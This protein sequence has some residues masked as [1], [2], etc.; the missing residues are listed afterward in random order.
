MD[1]YKS[2]DNELIEYIQKIIEEKTSN[3]DWD[4]TIDG[5][6]N[7]L[8]KNL[9]YEYSSS[10][11]KLTEGKIT[12]RHVVDKLSNNMGKL[13]FGDFK[14]GVDDGILYDGLS[15]T[16]DDY[17]RKCR[18]DT[19]F[20]AHALAYKDENGEDKSAIV[21]FDD[22]QEAT[23]DG[24]NQRLSGIDLQDLSDIRGTIFHEWTH[25]MEKCFIKSSELTKDDIIHR[26]GNSIYINSMLSPGLS[27]HEFANYVDN[28]DNLLQSNTKI[29]F[30][31][32]STIELNDK[33][34]PDKRIMHNQISEGATEFIARKVME[35]LGE[36]V[37]HPDRYSEQVKIISGIFEGRGLSEYLTMYLT[38]PHKLIRKL[39]N[40]KVKNK[41][42]LHYISDYINSS[43]L[44]RLFNKFKIDREGNIQLGIFQ[45]LGGKI[46]D[47]FIKKENLMLTQS[48][49][50]LDKKETQKNNFIESIKVTPEELIQNVMQQEN[51]NNIKQKDNK[52][53][54]SLDD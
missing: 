3:G 27:K 22:K 49:H 43:H 19:H 38:E 23:V 41:D 34:D 44:S 24:I 30:G 7:N 14:A 35:M 28:I 37:K 40:E 12:S 51:S 32:I 8:V 33:K 53:G 50:T 36:Q 9:L 46:K 47:L 6:S 20:G 29:P 16:S 42:M 4:K 52:D 54:P 5:Q 31:G 26:E 13:R 45:K 17:K 39:E 21:L 2:N 11:E 10:I 1:I 48:E 15:V 18:I 25:V